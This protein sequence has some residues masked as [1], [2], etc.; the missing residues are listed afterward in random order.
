MP[1]LSIIT[2][3]KNPGF[4]IAET[5]NSVITQPFKDYEYIVVD[6]LS[7]DG[8]TEYLQ[9]LKSKKKIN[10]L[11][12]EKDQGIYEAIN[13][14]ISASEGDYIGIIHAGDTYRKKIFSL[15]SPY[16][17]NKIDILYGSAHI[18]HEED[19]NYVNLKKNSHWELKKRNS[20]IHTSTFVKK[21]LYHEIGLYNEKFIIAG[22]YEFFKKSLD[23]KINFFQVPF[24][25]SNIQFGGIS[26]RI[27][28][29]NTSTKECT[30]IIFGNN[31]SLN[32]FKYFIN[33]FFT[34]FFSLI[35]KKIAN[36]IRLFKEMFYQS[37]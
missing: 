14:G 34:N 32:K 35:K 29:L 36:E 8:T 22:D 4:S 19:I 3:C 16:F 27:D 25:I 13:K 15:L 20:I 28:F 33:Y 24:S 5:V 31:F 21:K 1:L 18:I 17:N 9:T 2:V 23:K 26:T 12:V 10:K 30:Q 11:I 7:S 37:F 6:S